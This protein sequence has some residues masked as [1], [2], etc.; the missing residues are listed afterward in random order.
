MISLD[1]FNGRYNTLNDPSDIICFP[2]KAEDI[3][4]NIFNMIKRLNQ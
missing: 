2:N 4:F 3:N 1:K